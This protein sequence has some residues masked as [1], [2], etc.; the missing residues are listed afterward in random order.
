MAQARIT[1]RAAAVG[2]RAGAGATGIGESM[3]PL[4]PLR[5]DLGPPPAPLG[6]YLVLAVVALVLVLCA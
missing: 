1:V 2:V 5:R 6:A 3:I 4:R